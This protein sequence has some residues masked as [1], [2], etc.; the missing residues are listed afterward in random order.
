M[1][2]KN[3]SLL[4]NLIHSEEDDLK[5]YRTPSEEIADNDDDSNDKDE[6]EE[7][8]YRDPPEGQVRLRPSCVPFLPATVF[9]EYPFELNLVRDDISVIEPLRT[10]KLGYKSFWERICVRNAFKRAGF[11]KSTKS[12]TGLWSKHQND[13]QLNDLECLQKVNHFP[14]SWCVGR[15]DRLSRTMNTMKRLHGKEFDFHPES[16]ILPA[17]KDSFLR[18]LQTNCD[19]KRK[20]S[21][22]WIVK[23]CASSCGRGIS[24]V[25]ASQAAAMASKNK[26][27]LIQKYLM[28]PYLIDGKK[29]DLRIY[30]LVTGVDPLRVYVHKEGLTRISTSDY[31]VKN[32]SNRFAHLT[33]YSVNKKAINFKAASYAENTQADQN[34]NDEPANKPKETPANCSETEGFKWSLAAFKRWLSEREGNEKTEETFR[35]IHDLC[36]KTMIAAESEITPNVHR[37]V[38]YRTNCFEL[39]GLD[40]ILDSSLTPHLLEVNVSPSLMGSSPLDRRIKGMLLADIFHTVGLYPYDTQLLRKYSN[41]FGSEDIASS[42]GKLSNPSTPRN[43]SSSIKYRNVTNSNPFGFINLSKLMTNQGDHSFPFNFPLLR[44]PF[45]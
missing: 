30:V 4:N 15:K 39:F 27:Q 14:A 8:N 25:N 13:T 40:V 18:Y 6:D 21:N 1:S 22:L 3:N 36:V 7:T 38:A 9:F 10:R 28:D 16:F 32:L 20:D 2:L 24:V 31:S 5:L 12:W 23:P 34:V 41:N 17:D 33:N 44:I 45:L 35:K 42:S 37:I 29:F 26:K 19:K 11:E 43:E